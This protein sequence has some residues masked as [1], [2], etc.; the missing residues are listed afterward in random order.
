MQHYQTKPQA[1]GYQTKLQLQ[2]YQIK[3]QALGY[4]IKLLK[5]HRKS[6]AQQKPV[7]NF[8]LFHKIRA[9][10]IKH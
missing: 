6:Q 3:P 10:C 4:Q 5:S 2:H 8:I 9:N 1:L 7:V